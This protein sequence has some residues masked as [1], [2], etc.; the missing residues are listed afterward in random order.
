M[1]A[2]PYN[3]GLEHE[4]FELTRRTRRERGPAMVAALALLAVFALLKAKG[5]V[6]ADAVEPAFEARPAWSTRAASL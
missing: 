5:C 2:V 6:G 3:P 1:R 4:P